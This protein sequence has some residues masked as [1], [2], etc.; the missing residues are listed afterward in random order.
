M[1]YIPTLVQERFWSKVQKAGSD[2]CW[3]WMAYRDQKGYG[4]FRFAHM[5]IWRA[6]RMAWLLTNGAIPEGLCVCHT[7]DNPG[8]VNPNHLWVGTNAENH[9]D[10]SAKGRG[11]TSRNRG[12]SHGM[13]ILSKRDVRKIRKRIALGE[14]QSLIARDYKVHQS[15]IN[16]IKSGKNWSHV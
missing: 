15:T 14:T 4:G 6:H 12:E 1:S 5:G 13:A 8:C 10:K 9:A 7:C 11:R 3:E 2:E 16:N